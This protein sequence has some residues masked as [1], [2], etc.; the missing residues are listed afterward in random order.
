MVVRSLVMAGA[1]DLLPP[2]NVKLL[3]DGLPDSH[4]VLFEDS[5]HY[6]PIEEPEA[7]RAAIF[8]FLGIDSGA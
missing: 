8:G 3:H 7:F 2:E 6:A 5:A 1:H 4:F